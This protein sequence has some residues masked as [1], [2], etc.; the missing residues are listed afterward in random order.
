MKYFMVLLVLIG[1]AVT[2]TV[3]YAWAQ[4]V[5]WHYYDDCFEMGKIPKFEKF[6]NNGRMISCI[7]INPFEK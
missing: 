2:G 6:G 1:F 4:D 7:S 5:P 3:A